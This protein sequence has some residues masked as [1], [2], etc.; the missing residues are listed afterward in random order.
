MFCL[1]IDT[2]RM[3]E[4]GSWKGLSTV[5]MGDICQNFSR[6]EFNCTLI[7][8][9]TWLGWPALYTQPD[10]PNYKDLQSNHSFSPLFDTFLKNV[11]LRQLEHVIKPFRLSS[12]DAANVLQC[13]Q[14]KADFIY[15][16]GDHEYEA[17]KRDLEEYYKILNSGGLFF[18]DD[19]A[20]DLWDV[21]KAVTEFS[22]QHNLTLLDNKLQPSTL[23]FWKP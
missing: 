21:Q 2:I 11:K 9:D 20:N 17:V 13:Y 8:I 4:V 15:I 10:H 1:G 7:A 23:L 3:I 22:E 14:M 5:T 19:W 12:T 6:N 16:D 18:G